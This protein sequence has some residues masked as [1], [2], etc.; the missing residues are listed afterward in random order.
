MDLNKKVV[1]IYLSPANHH[2]PYANGATEKSQ[3]DKLAPCIKDILEN[4]YIGAEVYLPT[5]FAA[6]GQYNGR[7]E[8]AKR[9]GCDVYNALHTNAESNSATGGKA[10]GACGF[11]HPDYQLSKTIATNAV[12]ELNKICPFK[13][14]RAA[15]P[16]IYAQG[17]HI[18]LGEL[19]ESA[20]LGMCP[21]LIEHEFHDRL[22]GAD[23]IVNHIEEIAEADAKALAKA[24]GL[25]R[26][27]DVNDDGEVDNLD[28]AA[29]LK[30][31]A[32]LTEL[33]PDQLAA[34]DI[35][36]DGTVDNLDAAAILKH[37]AGII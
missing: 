26:K 30:Y 3:M 12:Q 4:R 31:D 18:N 35:N 23:W 8:E 2:K 25:R 33:P 5:V 20:A 32:G 29:V 16:A 14:N 22:Q 34:A 10:T 28:A 15:R 7:P 6:N 11:Y 27:G 1:K 17:L 19:R 36:G 37:D 21:V 24:L 13:S 9:L